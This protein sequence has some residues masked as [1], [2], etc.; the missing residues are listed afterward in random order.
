M[1]TA[2]RVAAVA[3]TARAA[4]EAP[5]AAAATGPGA[6]EGLEDLGDE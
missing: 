1:A 2:S 5:V 6:R 3:T 4:A